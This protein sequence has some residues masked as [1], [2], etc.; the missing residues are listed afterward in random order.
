MK[1]YR[2]INAAATPAK[3]SGTTFYATTAEDIIKAYDDNSSNIWVRQAFI[4]EGLDAIDYDNNLFGSAVIGDTLYICVT[5]GKEIEVNG[6]LV[7]PE[8]ALTDY[9]L[10]DLSEY[11]KNASADIIR[12][13]IT[14]YE[15]KSPDFDKWAI[16]MLNDG[17]SFS[18][19]VADYED[20]DYV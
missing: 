9:T 8:T 5:D 7:D 3:N 18:D 19:L 20:F 6:T 11:T 17:V 16:D 15:I 1:I 4:E 10:D 12:R 14:E 2:K 13:Y